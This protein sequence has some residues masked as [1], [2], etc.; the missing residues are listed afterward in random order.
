MS[1]PTCSHTFNTLFQDK[2]RTIRVCPRC[3]HVRSILLDHVDDVRPFLVDHCRAF[4][5][6]LSN[7]VNGAVGANLKLLWH[8]SGIEESINQPED[9]PK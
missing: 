8:T 5:P 6:A 1:C 3:G 9:R 4:E 7:P 2:F